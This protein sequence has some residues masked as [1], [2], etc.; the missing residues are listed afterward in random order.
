MGIGRES[1]L[2]A[3]AFMAATKAFQSAIYYLLSK[4]LVLNWGNFATP[5]P[6]FDNE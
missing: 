4:P 2:K 3:F 1:Y 6:T 5:T